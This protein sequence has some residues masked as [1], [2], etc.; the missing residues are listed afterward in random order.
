LLATAGRDRRVEY[1]ALAMAMTF[2]ARHSVAADPVAGHFWAKV[3]VGQGGK[4]KA[5]LWG[6]IPADVA[7]Q[8]G[9]GHE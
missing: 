5:E 8:S 6:L 9:A 3:T 4:R 7:E 2:V 1:V